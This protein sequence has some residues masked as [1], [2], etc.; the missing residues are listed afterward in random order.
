MRLHD[1]KYTGNAGH[2]SKERTRVHCSSSRSSSM[3]CLPSSPG[4]SLLGLRLSSS[5]SFA[6]SPPPPPAPTTYAYIHPSLPGHGRRFVVAVILVVLVFSVPS[7]LAS[8]CGR[9]TG[10]LTAHSAGRCRVAGGVRP[11]GRRREG[12]RRGGGRLGNDCL[13][14]NWLGWV[15]G[16]RE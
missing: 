4:L 15:E 7:P 6:S 2:D 5:P 12:E 14:G 3:P 16:A 8:V 9:S 13:E 1:L 10:R 11:G